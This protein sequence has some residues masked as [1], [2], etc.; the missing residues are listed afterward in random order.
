MPLGVCSISSWVL[1][2][3]LWLPPGL[4]LCL[5][6]PP[7]IT[8]THVPHSPFK[9]IHHQVSKRLDLLSPVPQMTC[10]TGDINTTSDSLDLDLRCPH[11]IR[12]THIPHSPFKIIRHQVSKWLDLLNPVPHLHNTL[13]GLIHGRPPSSFETEDDFLP[14][15]AKWW[16]GEVLYLTNLEHGLQQA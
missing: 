9:I 8:T 7:L 12:T 14:S 13:L 2:T 16:F 15:S 10:K 1:I 4:N 6:H 5:W 3:M 11:L